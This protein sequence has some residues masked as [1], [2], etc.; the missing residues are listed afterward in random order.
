MR[1]SIWL[2]RVET[3]TT[4]AGSIGPPPAAGVSSASVSWMVRK[5]SAGALAPAPCGSGRGASESPI[6]IVVATSAGS[7]SA[8]RVIR[9]AVVERSGFTRSSTRSAAFCA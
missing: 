8:F 7:V 5:Y 3:F 1:T 2:R 6:A 9:N 4:G